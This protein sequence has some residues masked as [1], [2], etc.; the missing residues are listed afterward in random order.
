MQNNII[1]YYIL[2]TIISC[3]ISGI[4]VYFYPKF[5]SRARQQIDKEE[6]ESILREA[7]KEAEAKKKEVLLEARD[8]AHRIR[9]EAEKE[10]QTRRRELQKTEQRLVRKEE[11][12]DKKIEELEKREKKLN[13]KER[14]AIRLKERLQ[15]LNSQQRAK[16]EQI[17]DLTTKEAKDLLMR[18]IEEEIKQDAAVTVKK[19]IEETKNQSE[20]ESRKIIT[21]AI[22]KCAVDQVGESTVSVVH[23]PNDEMKGRIIG[24]EG[25]NI[26]MLETLTGIDLI[27]DDT[28]EA[29][30]LSGFNPIRRE[31]AKL[32]L[33]K[34]IVDG[35]IHPARIEE[36]FNKATKD[37][38]VRIR[39]EGEQASFAAGVSGLHPELIN[40]LGKLRFRTSYG[41]NILHHS[42]EVSYLAGAIAAEIK[43]DVQ[44]A[45]RAGL[46]HDIG[47]AVDQSVEGPHAVI[48]GEILERYKESSAVIHAVSAHHEDI[49]QNTVE[50]VLIQACDAISAARPG[51]RRE[52][53]ESYLKRLEKLE[54]I[55]DSFVG[56]NKS[57]AI[58]AGREIR[59]IVK[60]EDVDDY[61]AVKLAKNVVKKIEKELEYPG[62]IKVTV[63]RETRAIEYAK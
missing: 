35:R 49:E 10:S 28:P 55:A 57:Y 13:L 34:L 60:P 15:Q 33:E 17:S 50:A 41:Q 11:T 48:G 2:I 43:A 18:E 21:L 44:I 53:L 25:R 45:K 42:I 47:K 24:R 38:E 51:A 59:I 36:M 20:K 32:T 9:S 3:I 52:T 27:I 23:L 31:I 46:L 5:G 39:E 6:R 61:T 58:Q 1:L 54:K 12:I 16:L 37:M 29:V 63:I 22:Q 14:E 8:E 19:I 56:V 40:L 7:N 30:I 4:I 62:Q 26:R